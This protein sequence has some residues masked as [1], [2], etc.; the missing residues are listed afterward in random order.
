MAKENTKLTAMMLR[1]T[2]VTRAFLEAE[3]ANGNASTMAD[4]FN[5]TIEN[6]AR[7]RDEVRRELVTAFG[8]RDALVIGLLVAR[9]VEAFE[10][11]KGPARETPEGWANCCA[12]IAETLASI[13]PPAPEGFVVP[14]A[15]GEISAADLMASW[16][17]AV[18]EGW[19]FEPAKDRA[20]LLPLE[21]VTATLQT[22][23]R[24]TAMATERE[25]LQ[26]KINALEKEL[27]AAAW[28]EAAKTTN[29]KPSK[30]KTEKVR[31]K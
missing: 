14:K 27:K 16:S 31:S 9:T 8:G 15:K 23:K 11:A 10:K 25:A 3:V 1:P 7:E 22:W 4:A 21:E 29:E 13:A 6:A 5:R 24:G 26:Q 30:S 18:T 2:A 17:R 12:M 28:A 19:R 20:A